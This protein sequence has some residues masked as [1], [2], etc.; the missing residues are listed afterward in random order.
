MP[1]KKQA[2]KKVDL[3]PKGDRN[4]DP[5]TN[6]AGAH[7]I[8]TGVGAALGGAAAGMAA[9]LVAGPVGAVIGAVIGGVAGGYAGKG[10]GEVI[11]PTVDYRWLE[12]NFAGRSYVKKGEKFDHYVP[13]YRYGGQA[14]TKFAGK[15]FEEIEPE[16]KP[17][18]DNVR[19][20]SN[21]KWDRAR[22]AVKDAYERTLQL[23]AERLRAEQAGGTKGRGNA[24]GKK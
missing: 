7:P 16:I 22:H 6:A 15:P 13:A 21:M 12:E 5:I 24:K 18:W 17:E 23:R 4:A 19:G 10:V 11:D 9:G 8:E 14:E 1:N 3:P 20:E 2:A